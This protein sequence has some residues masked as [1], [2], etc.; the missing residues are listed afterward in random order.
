MHTATLLAQQ[1]KRRCRQGWGEDRRARWRTVFFGTL[2]ILFF[3]G[4]WGLLVFGGQW[5]KRQ[6]PE[7]APL[8]VGFFSSLF[9]NFCFGAVS[10]GAL[11]FSYAS[12]FLAKDLE[13]LR[14]LPLSRSAFLMDRLFEIALSSA[15]MAWVVGAVVFGAQAFVFHLTWAGW[16]E[17]LGL[18]FMLLTIAGALGASAALVSAAVFPAGRLRALMLFWLALAV[19]IFYVWVRWQR[20]ERFLT[21]EGLTGLLDMAQQNAARQVVWTPTKL[22]HQA[23]V[24]WFGALSMQRQMF[25]LGLQASAALA[26]V[27]GLFCFS[28]ETACQKAILMPR[29]N[30]QALRALEHLALR[31]VAPFSAPWPALL[32]REVRLFLRDPLRLGQALMIAAVLVVYA[33]NFRL[34]VLR[35][36]PFS[37]LLTRLAF[38]VINLFVGGLVTAALAV[39]LIFPSVSLEGRAWWIL[40]ALPVSKRQILRSKTVFALPLLVGLSM[41]LIGVTQAVVGLRGVWLWGPV[42]GAA[43]MAIAL[44]ASAVAIGALFPQFDAPSIA[45][46]TTGF[47]AI[48]FM[49]GAFVWTLVVV[50]TLAWGLWLWLALH[51]GAWILG[52]MAAAATA[53][54]TWGVMHLHR[55][56]AI[57]LEWQAASQGVSP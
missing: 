8:L 44:T 35:D 9:V 12:F 17:L 5:L 39:R 32:G 14:S 19:A 3:A 29:Q 10:V 55:R 2:T 24:S 4:L 56:A 20:P 54:T 26:V 7:H 57:A 48:V 18:W 49:T 46:I 23:V 36:M 34:I 33:L 31:A 30:R 45:A 37:P 6:T 50:G 15:L 51:H 53:V 11:V 28:F 22:M 1:L 43:A 16:V 27:Y 21:V 25:W 41:V 38:S 52:G 40:D 42:M 13:L 47:G